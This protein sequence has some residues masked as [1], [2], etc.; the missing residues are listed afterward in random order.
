M[1]RACQQ[2]PRRTLFSLLTSDVRSGCA[3]YQRLPPSAV[4]TA[5]LQRVRVPAAG[6]FMGQKPPARLPARGLDSPAWPSWGPRVPVRFLANSPGKQ[7]AAISLGFRVA[8]SRRRDRSRHWTTV[9]CLRGILTPGLADENQRW[10]S[11][12]T[13]RAVPSHCHRLFHFILQRLM[14]VGPSLRQRRNE[15]SQR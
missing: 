13:G 3:L 7:R 15:I 9:G 11:S 14:G 2:A 12:L 8:S 4:D 10:L 6:R 5:L 1:C